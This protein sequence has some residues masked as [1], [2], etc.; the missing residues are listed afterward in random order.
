MHFHIS[1]VFLRTE[2]YNKPEGTL[3][4]VIGEEGAEEDIQGAM[5][6]LTEA[7]GIYKMR[8]FLFCTADQKLFGL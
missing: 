3:T 2:Q 4:G 1:S 8:R 6:R 5:G 7:G